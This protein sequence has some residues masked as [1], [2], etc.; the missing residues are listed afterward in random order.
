MPILIFDTETTGLPLW[1]E[2]S[3][4]QGQPHLVEIAARLYSAQG[5]LLDSFEAIIKPA[6]WVIPDDV[7]AVHGIT[8][9]IAMD[10]GISEAD[11][12]EGFLAL[13]ARAGLRAAHNVNFD[14]RIIRIALMRYRDEE[15][16]SAFKVGGKYCTCQ[17]SRAH[18]A[19][20]GNKLPTLGEAFKHF[21]GEDLVEAHRAM[22]DAT[23]CGR[24]YFALHGVTMPG[25]ET[26]QAA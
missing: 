25:I 1:K 12:L 16:A 4:A 14:D 26:N 10:T 23:A 6:G 17:Q 5:S 11:A 18:V 24:I 2:P 22:A 8:N 20:P 19:L 3:E 7:I 15:Q 13:Q 9:E 21:T